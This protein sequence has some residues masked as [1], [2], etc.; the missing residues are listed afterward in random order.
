M[1]ILKRLK[2]DTIVIKYAQNLKTILDSHASHATIFRNTVT[3][4]FL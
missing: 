4:I 1:I 3:S 2:K